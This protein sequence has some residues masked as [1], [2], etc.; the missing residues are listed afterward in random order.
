MEQWEVSLRLLMEQVNKA[1]P[2]TT[3]DENSLAELRR[4]TYRLSDAASSG[5]LYYRNRA[6]VAKLVP[7][8]VYRVKAR[9]I[10]PLAIFA[11][12]RD[13]I[14]L[15]EKW[16]HTFLTTEY[17]ADG[18][19]FGTVVG[20]DDQVGTVPPELELR[21][22]FDGSVCSVCDQPCYWTGPPAPA[23]WMH[24]TANAPIE[25]DHA[26][27]SRARSNDALRKWF[28]SFLAQYEKEHPE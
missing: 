23:P 20:V 22:Y 11:G 4:L 6:R 8:G 13:F 18:G 25:S 21:V 27:L 24:G 26:P 2:T 10:G 14:G 1:L 5:L 3:P 28:D 12:G 19:A 16:G 9:N 7:G 15:R 17:L